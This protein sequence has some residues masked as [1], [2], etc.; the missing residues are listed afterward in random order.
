M[1]FNQQWLCLGT[2]GKL[3]MRAKVTVKGRSSS[4]PEGSNSWPLNY[5]KTYH[6]IPYINVSTL[7]AYGLPVGRLLL[8]APQLIKWHL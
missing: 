3:E 7:A 1:T 8:R 4:W 2:G 5:Q 6:D